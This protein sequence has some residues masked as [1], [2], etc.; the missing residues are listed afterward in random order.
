MENL[1]FQQLWVFASIFL[2]WGLISFA[3]WQAFTLS[4][5]FLHF[6]Y[7]LSRLLLYSSLQVN[8][9]KQDEQN[10]TTHFQVVT[11]CS[12]E[13]IQ[14]C[15]T[16]PEVS[17][18]LSYKCAKGQMCATLYPFTKLLWQCYSRASVTVFPCVPMLLSQC[19]CSHGLVL[20][21][22]LITSSHGKQL[23]LA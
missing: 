3:G 12:S 8:F 14:S 11:C 1:A 16:A 17:Q 7:Q 4:F 21:I 5:I 10:L 19:K 22:I 6:I 15:C 13:I 23:S 9:H 18:C 20:E 2:F